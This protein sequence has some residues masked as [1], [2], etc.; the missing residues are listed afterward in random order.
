MLLKTSEIKDEFNDLIGKEVTFA[1][2]II[3][4]GGVILHKE[5]EK[6]IISDVEYVAGYWSKLC[7]D[8][9]RE[10]KINS[11]YINDTTH[12]CYLP[13]TFLELQ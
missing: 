1:N 7:P 8:I 3:T 9:Y 12:V 2:D 13:N 10:P 4:I 5:N 6:A 11:V